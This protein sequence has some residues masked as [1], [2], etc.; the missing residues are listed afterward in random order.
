MLL[1]YLDERLC[2]LLLL[3]SFLFISLEIVILEKSSSTT[4][5][6]LVG[7]VRLPD[8]YSD[9]E[10]K[11]ASC[12]DWASDIKSSNSS[13]SEHI[14]SELYRSGSKASVMFWRWGGWSSPRALS[15]ILSICLHSSIISVLKPPMSRGGAGLDIW[16][17]S[18]CSSLFMDSSKDF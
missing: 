13:F 17:V 3:N 2:E 7:A 10:Q 12:L 14:I 1:V 9:L 4:R 16:S 11:I 6:C 5:V 8:S 15:S 18:L